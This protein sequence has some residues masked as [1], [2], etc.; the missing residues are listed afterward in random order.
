VAERAAIGTRFWRGLVIPCGLVLAW[1]IVSHAGGTTSRLLV[2]PD[3]VLFAP[4]VDADARNLWLGL[5]ASLLRMVAGFTLGAVLGGILGLFMGLSAIAGKLVG[6]SFTGVRQIALFA[7]IPLLTAWFGDG[8][9][10][11]LVFIALSA[12]FPMALNTQ[13][14]VHDVPVAYRE[15][16]RVFRLSRRRMLTRVVVPGALPAICVGVE[17]ALINAWIGTVGAEYAMGMGRGVGTFLA[18]G[19]EQFRM[20]IVLLGVVALALVGFLLNALAR[21]TFR[22]LAV[23]RGS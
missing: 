23:D 10:A 9:T 21:R 15:V 4:F 14:G 16:A 22:R 19:R 6:P 7:W 12:L 5:G 1:A 18:A 11:K 3:R 13:Q 2:P 20:D 17:I 8:E